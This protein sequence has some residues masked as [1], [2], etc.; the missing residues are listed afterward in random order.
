MS[1]LK[2]D[3]IQSTSSGAATLTKQEAAKVYISLSDDTGTTNKSFNV[4]SVDDDATADA[5]VNLTSNMSDA[6]YP[7]VLGI[8]TNLTTSGGAS[9]RVSYVN[10]K[11]ASE[12]GLRSGYVGSSGGYIEQEVTG[13]NFQDYELAAFG[14]LA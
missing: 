2:A 9:A 12:I 1:T 10:S 13:S 11:S 14:D 5:G 8:H 4:S 7:V 3:T 6:V